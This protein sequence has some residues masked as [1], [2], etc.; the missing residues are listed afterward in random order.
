MAENGESADSAD[1]SNW[2]KVYVGNIPPNC[3]ESDLQDLFAQ[4]GPV[5]RADIVKNFGFVVSS[6]ANVELGKIHILKSD[7]LS[8]QKP[9]AASQQV[10]QTIELEEDRRGR[11]SI[12]I[13][14]DWPIHFDPIHR[15]KRT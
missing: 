13:E 4:Y 3:R 9:L 7:F 14:V 8:S 11:R 10:L 12:K 5:K 6:Q 2:T 1:T 15:L